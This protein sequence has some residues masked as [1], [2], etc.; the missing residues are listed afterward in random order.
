VRPLDI[1]SVL[2]IHH[3]TLGQ[4]V[5]LLSNRAPL[6]AGSFGVSDCLLSMSPTGCCDPTK[7]R[8]AARRS[9]DTAADS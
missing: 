7:L 8:T 1:A 2:L 6:D 5:Q 3:E 9:N 4:S